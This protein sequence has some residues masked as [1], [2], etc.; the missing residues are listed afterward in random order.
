LSLFGGDIEGG[1]QAD[2][3][4]SIEES[5]PG[6]S[7]IPQAEFRLEGSSRRPVADPGD[8]TAPIVDS[9]LW[10][11]SPVVSCRVEGDWIVR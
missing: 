3:G 10:L 8:G 9:S 4:K 2:E 1:A 7:T 6:L 5:G 11:L